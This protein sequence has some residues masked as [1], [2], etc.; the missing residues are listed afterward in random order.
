MAKVVEIVSSTRD[1]VGDAIKSLIRKWRDSII[2]IRRG[3]KRLIIMQQIKTPS[4]NKVNYQTFSRR[5]R[6]PLLMYQSLE[7][8]CS[9]VM[10]DYPW[11]RTGVPIP[12]V[13]TQ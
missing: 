2:V 5:Q 8:M 11:T 10:P 3:M 1:A 12:I 7:I 6:M 13:R 9:L 4:I